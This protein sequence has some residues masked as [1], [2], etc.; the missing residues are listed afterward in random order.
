MISF[1]EWLR[2]H[3]VTPSTTAVHRPA[4]KRGT[5]DTREDNS[6][7]NS[8]AIAKRGEAAEPG[9]QPLLGVL[10]KNQAKLG[11]T[12]TDT[13]VLTNLVMEWCSQRPFPRSATIAGRMGVGVRT[14]QRALATLRKLEVLAKMGSFAT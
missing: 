14:V 1:P 13:L 12:P 3:A 7:S 10:L 2:N 9:L 8:S 11:L 5:P 6:T 4:D